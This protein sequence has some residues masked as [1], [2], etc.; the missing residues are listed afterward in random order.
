MSPLGVVD[1]SAG[2]E[3]KRKWKGE[4]GEER[5][6]GEVRSG[7]PLTDRETRRGP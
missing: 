5:E 7:T 1:F 2:N 4:S 3:E 6:R